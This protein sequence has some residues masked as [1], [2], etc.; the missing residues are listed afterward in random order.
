MCFEQIPKLYARDHEDN[1]QAIGSQPLEDSVYLDNGDMNFIFLQA[2]KTSK[3]MN[4]I[5]CKLKKPQK[6]HMAN[7]QTQNISVP[8]LF[9]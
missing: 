5:F 7:K 3:N 4:F 2:K 1:W 9:S 8:L 6:T